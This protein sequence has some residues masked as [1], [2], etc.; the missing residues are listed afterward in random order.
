MGLF[1]K[2]SKE[3]KVAPPA[4]PSGPAPTDAAGIQRE[5]CQCL[6]RLSEGKLG[7]DGVDPRAHMFDVG[8]LD[9]FRSVELLAFIERRFGVQVPEMQLVGKLCTVEALS[10]H[11]QA[12]R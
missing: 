12:S 6:A 11:V 4:E 5:V 8:Y 1:S 7:P 10:S 3:P 9:S 2:K